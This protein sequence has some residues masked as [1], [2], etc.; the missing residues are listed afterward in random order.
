MLDCVECQRGNEPNSSKNKGFS[1]SGVGLQRLGEVGGKTVFERIR[2]VL[3][4]TQKKRVWTSTLSVRKHFPN[5][6]FLPERTVNI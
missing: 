1:A 4:I 2:S 3:A 6:D 5:Q